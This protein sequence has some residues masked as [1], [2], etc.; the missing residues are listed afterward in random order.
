MHGMIAIRAARPEDAE[1]L[2]WAMV[3]AA[4]GHLS[5]GWFDIVLQR[6]EDFCIAFCAKLANAKAKSWWHHSLFTIAELDG[7]VPRQFLGRDE[8]A[9]LAARPG[10]AAEA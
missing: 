6:P 1:F 4:R 8:V 7:A 2:G 10:R 5:R 3:M 9:L